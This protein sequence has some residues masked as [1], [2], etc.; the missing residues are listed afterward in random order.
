MGHFPT[1]NLG[2]RWIVVAIDH[3]ARYAKTAALFT[4]TAREVT[5]LLLNSVILKHGA[6]HKL[7]TD[8][9]RVFLSKVVS[10]ILRFSSTVNKP[11]TAYHVQANGTTERFNQTLGNMLSTCVFSD[12]TD[13]DAALPFGNIAYNSA[14]QATTRFSP[15]YLLFVP[16]PALL[17]HSFLP[18]PPGSTL[19]EFTS[20]TAAR[21][22]PDN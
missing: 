20:D 21:K 5:K 6:P 22:T 14:C 1:P 15:F 19:A 17:I 3:A 12:Y 18:F 9:G 4:A 10:E 8:H 11:T 13:W 7:V 16:K 2:N